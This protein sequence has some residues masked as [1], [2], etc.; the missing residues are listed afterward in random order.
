ML[1]LAI[2]V[3]FLP[4]PLFP[5]EVELAGL[6]VEG[7]SSPV[8]GLLDTVEGDDPVPETPLL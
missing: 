3:P 2:L 5:E 7:L 1:S 8:V 6:V 4:L